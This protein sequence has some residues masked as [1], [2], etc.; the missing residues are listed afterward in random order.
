MLYLICLALL[1]MSN[2]HVTGVQAVFVLRKY[3]KKIS[4]EKIKVN[5]SASGQQLQVILSDLKLEEEGG[6]FAS[7]YI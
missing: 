7:L 3:T 6:K 5:L 4:I 1:L 2:S